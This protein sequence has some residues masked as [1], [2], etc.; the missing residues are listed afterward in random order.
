MIRTKGAYDEPR[1]HFA[2][3]C[4]SIGCPALRPEAYSGARLAA[5]LADT[6][7]RFL[8]DRTRNRLTGD[9]FEVSS[10]FKWYGKDFDAVGGLRVFLADQGEAFGL[11]NAQRRSLRDGSL[12]IVFLDYDWDLNGT[13]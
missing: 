8:A 7:R 1:I 6:T 3:N 12:E 5:Q 13:P 4:A 11:T 9:R 2:V 10:L